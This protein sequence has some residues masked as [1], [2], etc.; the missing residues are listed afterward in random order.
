M[1]SVSFKNVSKTFAGASGPALDDLNLTIADRGLAVITGPPGSGKSTILRLLAGLEE[2]S[3][4]EIAIG[5]RSVQN[6]SPSERELAFVGSEN[7]LYPAMSVRENIA[8][9]LKLRKFSAK[10]IARRSE[11]AARALQVD[12]LLGQ[13]PREL[14]AT[15][16]QRVAIA[17]AIARQPKVLLL[18]EPL[19]RLEPAERTQLRAE[20]R[21]LQE[22]LATTMIYATRDPSEAIALAQSV[23]VLRAGRVEQ[24]DTLA[25]VYRMPANAHVA[26]FLGAP[27]MNF[28][29]GELKEDRGGLRFIEAGEGT[30]ELSLPL[31]G[32]EGLGDW[33]IKT[34]LL[35]LR[36]Q[37]IT[38]TDAK[39]GGAAD[40]FPALIDFVETL[41][42]E[43]NLH[44]QTGAH[45]LVV[46]MAG[47]PGDEPAGRRGRFRCNPARIYLFDAETGER[48]L[49]L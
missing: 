22:R 12:A 18:D 19:A 15:Q 31:A 47:R 28:V 40:I 37:D 4:G 7:A 24:H 3:Q 17:R 39:D 32:E 42:A 45:A 1:A 23:V 41:G 9:G 46:R 8:F 36:P 6:S 48:I 25:E 20:I 44:L 14:S 11:D 16:Q 49:P 34:V 2:V 13:Q 43:T 30:I 26:G 5:D 29:R 10:E 21:K 33:P 35:G 27:P 38:M